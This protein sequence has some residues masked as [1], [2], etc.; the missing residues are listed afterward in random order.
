MNKM[1]IFH[2]YPLVIK[3]GVLE[4]PPFMAD[5][6]IES[7]IYRG[8]SIAMFDVQR[9]NFHFPLVFLWV[10]EAGTGAKVEAAPPEYTSIMKM[11][12]NNISIYFL[13]S[14]YDDGHQHHDDDD[15][16]TSRSE[17]SASLNSSSS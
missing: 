5:V 15:L 16:G 10:S 13:L 7:S 9:V 11:K 17:P 14:S 2:S 6:P 4:N 12:H 8:F 3:H 1:V